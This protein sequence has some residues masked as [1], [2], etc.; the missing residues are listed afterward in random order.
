M[1][2]IFSMKVPCTNCTEHYELSQTV[3]Y[4]VKMGLISYQKQLICD[5]CRELE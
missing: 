3:E 5:R 2:I 4:L 1:M